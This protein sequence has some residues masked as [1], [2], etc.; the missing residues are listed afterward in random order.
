MVTKK[1]LLGSELIKEI[2]RIR[3]DTLWNMFAVRRRQGRLP[4]VDAEK[5]TGDLDDK[6]ALFLPGGIV[7]QD[8]EGNWI[9]SQPFPD[10]RPETFRALV[11]QAMRFDGANLIYP[12]GLAV[13]VKL[14]NTAFAC[15]ATSILENRREALRRGG[16]IGQH[17]PPRIRS[18]EICKSYCPTYIP[19]PYGS[20]TSLSSDL[21]VC[22][23]E[24]RLYFQ[25]CHDYY[26]LRD[27]EV[28]SL[29]AGIRSAHQPVPGT[30]DSILAPPFIVT[31]HN[32]RYRESILTG[33][34]RL[35]GFG[36]F[37][38]FATL[39]IEQTTPELLAEVDESRVQFSADEIVADFDGI[40]AAVVLRIY[41][42]T[43]PG[44]RLLKDVSTMLINAEKDMDVNVATVSAE[45]RARYGI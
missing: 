12:D 5:A 34:T 31:C 33:L 38:E 19:P 11:R 16:R 1:E 44:A 27:S 15:L 28:E 21:S 25:Q 42:R 45:A 22:L 17:R 23:C 43:S 30:D 10:R 3:I 41:P 35:S 6:G 9:H 13:H 40:Q 24:S 29:W 7:F 2:V 39:S 26:G 36:R 14:G 20:R 18:A 37:G 32:T 4:P 8:W